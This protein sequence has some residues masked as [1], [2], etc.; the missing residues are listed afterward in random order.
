MRLPLMNGVNVADKSRRLAIVTTH[1]IQ[2]YAPWFR[3]MAA[4]SALDLRVFYLWDFGVRARHDPGFKQDVKWDIPL[5]EGYEHEFVPNV[6]KH[7]GTDRFFGIRNAKLESRINSWKPDAA[8]LIGYNYASLLRIIFTSARRRGFPLLMRGDSHRLAYKLQSRKSKV[9]NR[10]RRGRLRRWIIA[11]IFRR[12]NALLYV[13][14]ANREYFLWHGVPESK[15]F[16]SPHAVDNERFMA[17]P[18]DTASEGR[19][20]RTEL[21]IPQSHPLILFAGKFE[22]KKRP[23]DLLEAFSRLGRADVSLLFVGSGALE[24]ELRERSATIPNVFFAPFQNQSQMP[25]TYAAADLFVLPSYGP[26]ETWGL[27]VNE[28]LCL[29]KPVIV[30]SHVGCGPDLVRPNHN[31]LVCEA[32][33]IDSL[34]DAL[35]SALRDT[36]QL[37]QW[38]VAGKE[39]ISNYSYAHAT[40]GLEEA[41]DFASANR[42]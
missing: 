32:G 11:R 15:L 6:S 5:L 13:G 27:A 17:A 10:E 16:F 38:G 25:R 1:P 7:P 21:G 3:W 28:A 8:L 18:A 4:H 42:I 2:Y 41:L 20:W 33:N 36:N 14:Q 23:L 34:T 26:E 40:R 30:S 35:K 24:R 29:A 9:E 19:R 22:E 31:G 37:R 39:I 12:F